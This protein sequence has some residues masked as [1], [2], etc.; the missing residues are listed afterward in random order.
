[1][2]KT[3][4]KILSLL[5]AV[6]V[7]ACAIPFAAF[8][9]SAEMGCDFPWTKEQTLLEKIV[10]RDGLI[11]GVWFPW[12]NAGGSGHNLTGNEVMAKYYDAANARVEMDYY[13]ADKIY[14]EI[15]NLKAMG[16]NMMAYG[17][18][19]YG[20]GVVYD[21]YGDVI[22]IK[23]DYLDNVRRLL[24]MCRE[25][26]MPVMWN[27]YFHSSSAPHYHG[28]QGWNIISRMLGDRTVADHYAERFVRPL[29]KVLAEYP[30]V[31]ALVSIADEPENE[32]NDAE[33]GNHFDDS[34][35]AMFGVNRDD[36]IYFMKGINDVCKKELPNVPRTVASNNRNKATYSG[37]GLDL[38][39]HNHYT[40]SGN[41]PSVDTFFTDAD[42]ILTEYNIGGDAQI[43]DEQFAKNLQTF[44]KNFIKEGYKGGFQ[45]CWLPNATDAAY[46]M[47]NKG[48]KSHTDFKETVALTRYYID[49][50]RAEYQGK[51]IAFDTPVLYANEGTG[52]VEWIPS[53]NA[54]K[55][56]IERSDDGG[57]TWKTVLK[58]ADAAPLITKGKGV[59]KDTDT[60]KPKSGFCYRVTMTDGKNKATS[61]PN[62]LAGA[63]KAYKVTY[64]APTIN[65]PTATDK[66]APIFNKKTEPEKARL[67]SFGTS[68]NR[69]DDDSVNLIKNGSFESTTGAQWNTSTFLKYAKV[70]SDK[71]APEGSK[72]L[73]FDTSSQKEGNYY[74]FTVK[75]KPGTK[76]TF[77]TWIKG[78][79]LGVDNEGHASVGVWDPVLN[80]FMVYLEF[81]RD[82]ARGSRLD[83]QIYPTA[84]DDE[85][86]L[87]AVQFETKADETEITIALYGKGS[88]MWLDGMALF[89][90]SDGTSY[91]GT[92]R[93]S[94]LSYNYFYDDVSTCDP[95]KSLTQNVRLDDSKNTFWQTGDGW[96]NGFLNI[97]DNKTGFGKSIKYTPSDA[98]GNY[99]IKWVNIEPNTEYIFSGN[100]KILK[101]GAGKIAL[102]EDRWLEPQE[103][104]F[105]EFDQ[106][107]F[108]EDWFRFTIAFKNTGFTKVGIAVCDA[109]GEALIDNIRLF[110]ASDAKEVTDPYKDPNGG[111]ATAP[112]ATVRPT[113]GNTPTGGNQP[114]TGVTGQPTGGETS[115]SEGEPTI[116]GDPT[117]S[118]DGTD[119]TAP[120]GGAV[121]S[122]PAQTGDKPAQGNADGED[123]DNG[124][125]GDFPWLIIAVV[126]AVLL[127]GGGVALFL[128]L[129]KK[130]KN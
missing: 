44:R 20:E 113:G 41:V 5:C 42:I 10:E 79:Y 112:V 73:Y 34:I 99:Y 21:D 118:A 22:G 1:M 31:V 115:P 52:L 66:V 36:M 24:N 62:N 40:S 39:G 98:V 123:Q 11:D 116:G 81:Y 82:T 111:S 128:I 23:Q 68:M 29:C 72:S 101:G 121:A 90:V 6:V 26:G 74:K 7:M 35:R 75:V 107:T 49:E 27:V 102:I 76:Y 67:L 103:G 14:Q 45:W 4:C 86:H 117:D 30:D 85:W 56:T 17:G 59:Y 95:A 69:P 19:I 55:V 122:K 110:K 91:M 94:Y 83:Q 58:D 126:G 87:R 84:W 25:I 64:K 33:Y 108:G 120:N 77:S 104:S 60:T 63:D 53:R 12:F 61:T 88:Q 37:F 16:F 127:I 80:G 97:V 2:K 124:G 13:G 92:N 38:M 50:Y 47:L 109:G 57:K 125:K 119:A 106:D 114:T 43:T 46:Y 100:V 70:V 78:D 18:S 32:I 105:V 71:T 28:M 65:Y 93:S 89:E 130:K 96:R 51:K 3:A 129:N 48:A 54:T 9:V 15:Y 8:T